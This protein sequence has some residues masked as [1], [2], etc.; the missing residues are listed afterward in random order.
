MFVKTKNVINDLKMMCDVVFNNHD[1][2]S[3]VLAFAPKDEYLF[4]GL[5]NKVEAL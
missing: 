4:V 3:A 5:V 2:V 1:L